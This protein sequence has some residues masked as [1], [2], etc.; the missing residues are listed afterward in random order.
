MMMMIIIIIVA[1]IIICPGFNYGK[2]QASPTWLVDWKWDEAIFLG[3]S[4]RHEK[5]QILVPNGSI[6]FHTNPP[7][8]CDGIAIL[9]TWKNDQ[10]P[11][12]IISCS[13]T[14]ATKWN[15]MTNHL[16][17]RCCCCCCCCCCCVFFVWR[18][19]A[20]PAVPGPIQY[21]APWWC[22][23]VRKAQPRV[24][25]GEI[26]SLGGWN[27]ITRWNH[28]TGK[29]R[30]VKSQDIE[31]FGRFFCIFLMGVLEQVP[32]VLVLGKHRALTR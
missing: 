28:H 30:F 5:N 18:T 8:R 23:L 13:T 4:W 3:A 19:S 10:I 27:H 31:V 22:A 9:S 12:K 11:R 32:F 17:W 14:D 26:L 1:T 6:K 16:I 15:E 25:V 20:S 29:L 2:I 24:E 7:F 21:S